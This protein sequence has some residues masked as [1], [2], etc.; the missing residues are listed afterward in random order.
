MYDRVYPASVGGAE[1]WY[2]L[3]AERLAEAG[4]RV[5]YLTTRHEG[6][7]RAPEIPGVRVLSFP[8]PPDI[9]GRRRRKVAPMV[10]FGLA[11]GRHLYIHGAEYDVVHTSAMLSWAALIAGWL[12][13]HRGYRLVLDWWE[14]WT[15]RYWS[16]YVGQIAGLAGWLMQRQVSRLQHQPV[17][18]S[19]LHATR[20][21]GLRSSGA[22]PILRG[23]LDESWGVQKPDRAD[24]L[25]VSAGR[26]IPEKQVAAVIP[27]LSISRRSLPGL[28]AV[29]FGAGPDEA[30][31][32]SAIDVSGLTSF[33]E[34]PGFVA[35]NELRDT[36]CRALCLILLSRREGYGLIVAE[37]A[38]LGVPSIVLCHPDSAASELI[39][40]GVNGVLCKSTHPTEVAGAII[41]IHEAG[42]TMR[43]STFN[44]FKTH[45]DELT[46]GSSLPR[47][48]TI[49]RGEDPI[50]ELDQ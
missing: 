41:R 17:A 26:M 30:R 36:L 46:V 5:T 33:V 15:L 12:A 35:D 25:V 47:L 42:P 28:R 32:R 6:N 13:R 24:P 9:Y 18:Y 45:A 38:A 29:L 11:V 37:A 2:R 31:V 48:L 7:K 49:Y 10:A 19:E 14:I 34:L 4:H 16:E 22:I 27:A 20:L 21:S 43:Q 8:A 23:L 39:I 40:D 44:W 50:G 1:R 3:L